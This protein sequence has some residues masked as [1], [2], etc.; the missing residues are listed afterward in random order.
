[1]LTDL[2][3]PQSRAQS[4][5]T[6]ISLATM[7][8]N[9][10]S[11]SDYYAKMMH[12]ADELATSAAPLR[13]DE[14]N[15]YIPASLEEDYNPI[16]TAIVAWVDPIS[17]SDHDLYAQL[18][19]FEQH[20]HLQT[21][22]SSARSSSA[23]TAT[24]GRGFAR[25]G[26]GGSDRGRSQSRGRSSSGPLP[27]CQVCLKFGHTANNCW[28]HFDED[29]VPELRSAAATSR[30]SIDHAWYTDSGGALTI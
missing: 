10:L 12:Y 8:K 28:H 23:M 30:P 18:L 19:S 9:H 22:A 13:D 1:M 29:Y 3:L 24:R 6:R 5:N 11:V 27:Q 17:P 26:I 4:V 7:K 2:Y 25:C 14:F 21:H 15:A 20:T 16:F